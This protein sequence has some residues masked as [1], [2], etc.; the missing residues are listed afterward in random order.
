MTPRF[1]KAAARYQALDIKSEHSVPTVSHLRIGEHPRNY[2]EALLWKK[3]ECNTRDENG[4]FIHMWLLG[5]IS[6]QDLTYVPLDQRCHYQES[7][8]GTLITTEQVKIVNLVK[9]C[10][11]LEIEKTMT[12]YNRVCYALEA[13]GCKFLDCLP[14]GM[15]DA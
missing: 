4:A 1:K 15:E 5:D 7:A 13:K 3:S 6:T 10:D 14:M 9:L 11:Q 12:N 2:E 8:H